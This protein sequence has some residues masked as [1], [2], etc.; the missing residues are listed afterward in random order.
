[1]V[2]LEPIGVHLERAI[3]VHGHAA[4]VEEVVQLQRHAAPVRFVDAEPDR[5]EHRRREG[6]YIVSPSFASSLPLS[7]RNRSANR[8]DT[9]ALASSAALNSSLNSLRTVDVRPP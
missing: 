7:N 8:P 9:S 4:V 2:L 6:V 5:P 1:D 3:R